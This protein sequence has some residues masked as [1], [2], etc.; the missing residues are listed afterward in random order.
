L[1]G[2]LLPKKCARRKGEQVFSWGRSI[3]IKYTLATS[4]LLKYFASPTPSGMQNFRRLFPYLLILVLALILWLVKRNQ[5]SSAKDLPK[6]NTPNNRK[7]TP[8]TDPDKKFDNNK[9]GLNRNTDNIKLTKHAR[10]RMECR[11]ITMREV[12]EIISKGEINYKKTEID[13]TPEYVLEGYSHERQHIRVVVAPEGER[14]V[15][16][17]V[18]DLEEDWPCDCDR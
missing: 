14:L 9:P 6:R 12:K 3:A 5:E 4:S 7:T 2:Y 18:I 1:T 11:H 17:T 8:R 15:L 10:C 13:S 16:I